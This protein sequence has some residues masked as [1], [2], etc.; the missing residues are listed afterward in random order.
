MCRGTG[1]EEKMGAAGLAA[2]SFVM[3]AFRPKV[4]IKLSFSF[5]FCMFLFCFVV[6][7]LF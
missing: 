3:S 5:F 2:S 1:E 4:Y 6:D 7:E